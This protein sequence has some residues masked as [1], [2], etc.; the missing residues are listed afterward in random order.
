MNKNK[1]IREILSKFSSLG[2][3]VPLEQADIKDILKKEIRLTPKK[4]AKAERVIMLVEGTNKLTLE[5]LED[6]A[7]KITKPLPDN[8][9]ILW[10]VKIS[11]G[12]R[13]DKLDVVYIY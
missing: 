12:I 13:K 7:E 2:N 1:K 4:G 6:M 8:A 5:K 9:Q 11:E 3:L 10:G